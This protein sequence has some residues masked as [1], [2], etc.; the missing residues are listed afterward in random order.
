MLHH[1]LEQLVDDLSTAT[2]EML[3]IKHDQEA[4][5]LEFREF[6]IIY[7]CNPAKDAEYL[8]VIFESHD[9]F[10]AVAQEIWG[11]CFQDEPVAPYNRY[12][13]FQRKK[14]YSQPIFPKPTKELEKL[15]HKLCQIVLDKI[16]K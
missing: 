11:F 10:M 16:K 12:L 7:T 1:F 8:W 13:T 15:A 14:E 5:T 9:L 2:P 3:R 4:T 6:D